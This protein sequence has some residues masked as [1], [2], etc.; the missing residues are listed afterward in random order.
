MFN[1]EKRTFYS[2]NA[3]ISIRA[4]QQQRQFENEQVIN[5][6]QNETLITEN[7]ETEINS[8]NGRHT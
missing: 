6:L 7:I 3:S 5:L 4:N 2:I 8:P 1:T